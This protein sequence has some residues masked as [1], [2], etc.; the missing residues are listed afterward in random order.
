MEIKLEESTF[1]RAIGKVRH[2]IVDVERNELSFLR[3]CEQLPRENLAALIAQVGNSLIDIERVGDG[4][5]LVASADGKTTSYVGSHL[6]LFLGVVFEADRRVRFSLD[7]D[8]EAIGFG[9]R[10]LAEIEI[11]LFLEPGAIGRMEIAIVM[12]ARS[13]G[14]EKP[15]QGTPVCLSEVRSEYDA[16]RIEVFGTVTIEPFLDCLVKR[17]DLK[18]R[19]PARKFFPIV[20]FD[21]GSQGGGVGCRHAKLL[22]ERVSSSGRG[23][24]GKE[25][26]RVA[27]ADSQGVDTEGGMPFEVSDYPGPIGRGEISE[28]AKNPKEELGTAEGNIKVPVGKSRKKG[29]DPT[30]D[31]FGDRVG[32]SRIGHRLESRSVQATQP[33]SLIE[34]AMSIEGAPEREGRVRGLFEAQGDR[35]AELVDRAHE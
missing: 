28:F 15:L 1:D 8:G 18:L 32:A 3:D 14:E 11:G 12:V 22:R 10:P 33:P 4:G 34:V 16:V 5:V 17:F 20:G 13:N 23:D 2:R 19:Q 21:V 27:E 29:S 24:R 7:L 31:A 6:E 9:A 25:K 30:F 26:R 35:V